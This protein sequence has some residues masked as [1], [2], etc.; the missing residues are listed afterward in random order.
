MM[1]ENEGYDRENGGN[2]DGEYEEGEEVKIMVEMVE[3]VEV[4]V[5]MLEI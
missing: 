1:R 2:D 3:T 4:M 5:K